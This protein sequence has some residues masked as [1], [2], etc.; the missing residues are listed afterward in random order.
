MNNGRD[1]D[2]FGIRRGVRQGC[3]LSPYLFVLASEVLAKALRKNKDIRGI[4]VNEKEIKLSQYADDTTLIL[5]GSKKSVLSSLGLLDDFHKASGL[6]LNDKKTEVFGIGTNCGKEEITLPGRN[7]KVK[8]LGVWFSIDP[9]IATDLNYHEKLNNVR[10][11]LNA[12]AEINFEKQ[13]TS[14]TQFLSQGIW[15]NSLIRIATYPVFYPDWFNKGVKKVKDLKDDSDNFLSFN[16]FQIKFN[17]KACPLKYYGLLSA[18]KSLWSTCQNNSNNNSVNES[19]SSKI[20]KP[21][22]GSRLIYKKLLSRLS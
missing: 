20:L 1:S 15:H 3:P 13:I 21:L 14:K 17:L 9:E 6:K 8:A 4:H 12:W 7:F 11:I 2:F 18:L 19:F 10:N 16:E 22:S 5:D